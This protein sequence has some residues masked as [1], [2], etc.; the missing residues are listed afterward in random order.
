[1]SDTR[2]RQRLSL[3]RDVRQG[4]VVEERLHK[5]LANAGLGSRRLLEER[6]GAGEGDDL[7]PG[8]AQ[9]GVGVRIAIIGVD[10]A[11]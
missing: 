7:D 4:P 1:M 2:N 3:N 9:Q 11:G 6:I 5:V 8:L 10:H